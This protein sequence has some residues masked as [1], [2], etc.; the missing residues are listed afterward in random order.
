MTGSNLNNDA[1]SGNNQHLN[2]AVRDLASKGKFQE[3]SASILDQA[4]EP[5]QSEFGFVGVVLGGQTLR[6][7]FHEGLKWH[8]TIN[9][10][11]YESKMRA[12]REQHYLDFN[13]SENLVSHVIKH[14]ESVLSNSPSTDPRS[15]GIPAGHPR[16]HSFLGVPAIIENEFVGMIGLANRASGY[17][18]EERRRVEGLMHAVCT[19][20]RLYVA[21]LREAAAASDGGSTASGNADRV[22]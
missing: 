21:T 1:P 8:T 20:Y 12:Y 15:G 22:V 3:A 9:R 6:L 16:L 17:T 10:A 19:V 13:E 4:L 18:D 5:T 7:L 11:F 14:K 2:A